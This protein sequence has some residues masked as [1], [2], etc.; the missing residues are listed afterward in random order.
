MNAA[1]NPNIAS[2]ALSA[3]LR[4]DALCRRF[5]DAWIAGDQP[6]LEDYLAQAQGP[7]KQV[8]FRELL[9]LEVDYRLRAGQTPTQQEYKARFPH[10]SDVIDLL[11]KT[12]QGEQAFDILA[13]V[14]FLGQRT[15]GWVL[16]CHFIRELEEID[17]KRLL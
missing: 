2:L 10:A 5:E 4:V 7:E 6:S 3:E 9:R 1:S 14:V 13:C 8:L 12:K 15:E 16:G 17:L 11:L